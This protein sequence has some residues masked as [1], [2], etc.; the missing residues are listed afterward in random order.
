MWISDVC[1]VWCA[2]FQLGLHKVFLSNLDVSISVVKV[3]GAVDI[4][5]SPLGWLAVVLGVGT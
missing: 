1:S 5:P 4:V 3:R 2:F